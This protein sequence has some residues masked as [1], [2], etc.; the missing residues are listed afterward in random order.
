LDLL[1]AKQTERNDRGRLD[2]GALGQ[3]VDDGVVV[4]RAGERLA[5]LLLGQRT[6]AFGRVV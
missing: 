6:A 4:D 2:G 1:R 5:D 3:H